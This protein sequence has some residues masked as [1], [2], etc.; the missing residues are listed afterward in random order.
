MFLYITTAYSMQQN[1]F[2][3][4]LVSFVAVGAV[5]NN[6]ILNCTRLLVI[7][8]IVLHYVTLSSNIVIIIVSV[9]FYIFKLCNSFYISQRLDEACTLFLCLP[10]ANNKGEIPCVQLKLMIT[11]CRSYIPLHLLVNFSPSIL[12]WFSFS[13]MLPWRYFICW[14]FSFIISSN[15]T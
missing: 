1:R 7:E 14:N 11:F 9:I 8:L 15:E 12:C 6:K 4:P 13:I 2:E 10:V 3:S 5:R